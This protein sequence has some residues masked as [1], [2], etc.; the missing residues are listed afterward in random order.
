MVQ[1]TQ[2]VKSEWVIEKMKKV[3]EEQARKKTGSN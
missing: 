3:F 2:P 1:E